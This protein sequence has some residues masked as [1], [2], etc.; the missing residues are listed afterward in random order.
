MA[1]VTY[2][3]EVMA[4]FAKE[5]MAYQG[6]DHNGILNVRWATVGPNPQSQK[7]EACC[8][9]EQAAEAIRA[10]LPPDYMTELER[11][12]PDVSKR[13]KIE[14]NFRSNTTGYTQQNAANDP[15]LLDTSEEALPI[16]HGG[17]LGDLKMN[18]DTGGIL[19]GSVLAALE[20]RASGVKFGAPKTP[21]S[22][23][24]LVG[25]DSDMMTT[26]AVCCYQKIQ[27]ICRQP[28]G[29]PSN[30]NTS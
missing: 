24:P 6:L 17:S 27:L 12:D 19:S 1:F 7:R 21:E 10:A 16:E 9:H 5:A 28:V 8:I 25:Y 13:R 26:K 30:H 20:G 2:Y 15:R 22:T 4:Q 11:Q 14:E 3:T 23:R 18:S 29:G